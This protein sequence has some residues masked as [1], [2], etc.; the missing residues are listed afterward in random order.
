MKISNIMITYTINLR[1]LSKACKL[2]FETIIKYTI[3]RVIQRE[4]RKKKC[5]EAKE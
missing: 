1:N 4:E 2:I 3:F 5:I